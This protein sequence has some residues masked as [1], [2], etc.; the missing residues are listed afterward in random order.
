[1]KFLIVVVALAALVQADRSR[2]KYFPRARVVVPNRPPSRI[3]KIVTGV[4]AVPHDFPH[5][6]ALHI[7]GAFCGGSIVSPTKILTAAH[8][9][10]GAKSIVVV[11]G[12][13]DVTKEEETQQSV[14]TTDHVE[15]E[16]WNPFVVAND[17][18]MI[19]LPRPLKVDGKTV[20]IVQLHRE[21][22]HEGEDVVVAGWG[23]PYDSA[24][25]I[26]PVLRHTGDKVIS[27]SKCKEDFVIVTDGNICMDGS[28]GRSACS[29]DSG[30]PLYI[31]SK[32]GARENAEQIGLVSFGSALGCSV[33]YPSVYTRISTYQSWI[34]KH[35]NN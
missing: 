34:D 5:I 10:D 23:K 1:M 11:A 3:P 17:I 35:T 15:H 6:V 21:E 9:T 8:C 26:S 4:E 22:V 14:V 32:P 24:T 18:A 25:G 28:N 30:G 19:T 33:G 2:P 29:G 13:H 12:A 16:G 31:N 7:D 27:N 20:K